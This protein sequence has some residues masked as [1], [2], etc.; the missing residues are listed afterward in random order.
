MKYRIY[1]YTPWCVLTQVLFGLLIPLISLDR[2]NLDVI[3]FMIILVFINILIWLINKKYLLQPI[4]IWIEDKTIK[5]NYLK[6]I[7]SRTER[8]VVIH[9][10]KLVRFADYES[11]RGDLKFKIY[12]NNNRSIT[13]YKSGIWYK[14]DDFEKLISDFKIIIDKY[15]KQTNLT[16]K[17]KQRNRIKYGDKTN[18]I[19]TLLSF[20]FSLTLGLHYINTLSSK[21]IETL[22]YLGIAGVF[23]FIIIGFIN[24]KI[25]NKNKSKNETTANSK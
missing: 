18:L 20:G 8:C 7:L 22:D 15:N 14:K 3:S 4:D 19:I 11:G 2:F 17:N 24:L 6:S 25:H 1:A 16:E 9:F 21:E 23:M 12:L 13:I 5:F 10:E